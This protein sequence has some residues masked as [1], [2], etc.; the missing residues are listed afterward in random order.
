MR[1]GRRTGARAI[2]VVA[3]LGLGAAQPSCAD[4]APVASNVCGNS[5]ID[6]DEDCD[7]HPTEPGTECA[8]A[9]TPNACRFVC[10]GAASSKAKC[11]TGWGCGQDGICRE[12]SGRLA[13]LGSLV[14][15]ASPHELRVADFNGDG[16]PDVLLLGEEN[17]VGLTPA[18]IVFS[19]TAST[20]RSVLALPTNIAAPAIVA[21]SNDGTS[22]L[23]FADLDGI[24]IFRARSEQRSVFFPFPT[25]L[26]PTGTSLRV[27]PMDVVPTEPGD[28][29]V[30][31]VDRGE[32]GTTLE[33]TAGKLPAAVLT[34]LPSGEPDLAGATTWGQ[35]DEGAPCQQIVLPYRGSTEVLHFTPCVAGG[36]GV[37]WNVGGALRAV[38]LPPG[39]MLDRGVT[40]VDLDLD[41][42]LDLLIG[43][44]GRAFVAW[45][46][47]DGTFTSAKNN[48]QIDMA[49]PYSL[50]M[51]AGGDTAFPLAAADLNADGAIDFVVSSGIVISRPGGYAVAQ[52]NAGSW[53]QAVIA[54]FN[55]DGLPD[56][57]AGSL[58]AIDIDFFVNAGGGLFNPS[59]IATEGP[60]GYFAVGDF[61]GDLVNDL[62]FAQELD[63]GRVP[64][65]DLTIAFGSAKGAPETPVVI[66]SLGEIEQLVP[67]RISNATGTDG[68]ADVAVISQNEV[69]DT[70]AM[71]AFQGNGSRSL[72]APLPLGG[73]AKPALAVALAV[74]LFGN[75]TP[76]LAAVGVDSTTGEL[77]FWQVEGNKAILLEHLIPSAP[78][79]PQFHSNAP[80]SVASFRYNAY[81]AAGD[82]TGDGVDEIILVAPYGPTEDGA[83]LVIADYDAA[84]FTFTPRAEQPFSATLSVD[85][86]LH[87]MDVDGDG[88]LDALLTTGT[89][90]L[91][92]D[93][94]VLWGDGSGSLLTGAPGR[95]HLAGGVADVACLPLPSG[96]G[97]DLAVVSA[98]GVSRIQV[99][100]D[101]ELTIAPI[102]D[103][104]GGRGL[105]AGDFNGDGLL[106]LAIQTDSGLQLYQSLPVRQ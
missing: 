39:A 24:S 85:S 59:A 55:A 37:E 86:A 63:Q 45:G 51:E 43:A 10:G 64:E 73:A 46:L 79:S 80:E 93:L 69:E 27:L 26:P 82:L 15:F 50:P 70:D 68:I 75:G 92:G 47:G 58:A 3:L 81:L 44:S 1:R 74:G 66:A 33:R 106:D 88:H 77:R 41:Q 21:L 16:V 11:P 65:D 48:G 13:P 20:P 57:A 14:P 25:L 102:A 9:D 19:A 4:F 18:R 101:R 7:A 71:F 90:E 96:R 30:A 72:K 103:L 17:A 29:I 31:F 12:P 60:T 49:G 94:L 98:A 76:A 8:A 54:D 5:V 36:A 89:D 2:A 78:L 35:L 61:D 56:V 99:K 105:G 104:A 42:H 6:G 87:L 52:S 95:V 53:S 32:K 97:C 91:P 67:A 22:D 84:A 28:E 23:G 38:A 100:R 83:A 62:A 40:L 34:S